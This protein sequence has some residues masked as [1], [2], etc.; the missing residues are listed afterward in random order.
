MPD[1]FARLTLTIASDNRLE[2][3]YLWRSALIS[4]HYSIQY[5]QTLI[6]RINAIS[7]WEAF[8]EP[9]TESELKE[10]SPG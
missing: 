3:T 4:P 9:Q 8:L 6:S 7:A 1:P 10:V 5:T 2:V